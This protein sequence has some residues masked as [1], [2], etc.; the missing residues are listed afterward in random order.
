M[1]SV[2]RKVEDLLLRGEFSGNAKLHGMCAPLYDH[3]QW[4]WTFVDLEGVEPT[5]NASAR[6]LRNAVIWRKLSFGTQSAK[7]SRFVET[8]LTTVET[9]RQHGRNLFAFLTETIQAHQTR[10]KAPTLLP[11]E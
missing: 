8:I 9:C 11:R 6:A 5:N 4:L 3:H 2:R 7:G 1:R 10:H